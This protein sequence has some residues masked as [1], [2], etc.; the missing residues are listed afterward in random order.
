MASMTM[1]VRKYIGMALIPVVLI[2]GGILLVG[3]DTLRDPDRRELVVQE[4]A[5]LG[6]TGYNKAMKHIIPL[7]EAGKL[8]ASERKQ[9]G[10]AR[11]VIGAEICEKGEEPPTSDVL[12]K[13]V[14]NEGVKQLWALLARKGITP[15][16]PVPT[17]K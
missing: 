10:Y 1:T 14:V 4:T 16:T 13:V 11:R 9:V 5:I 12:I 7:N 6:C 17:P 15:S 3:C 2:G 8:D